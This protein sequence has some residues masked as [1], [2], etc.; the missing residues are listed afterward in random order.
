MFTEEFGDL[1]KA[2]LDWAV[3]ALEDEGAGFIFIGVHG[4]GSGTDNFAAIDDFGAIQSD[5]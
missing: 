4:H 1:E 3:V 2:E 5:G